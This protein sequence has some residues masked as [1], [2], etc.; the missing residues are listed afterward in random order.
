MSEVTF[1]T[2]QQKTNEMF[3]KLHHVRANKADKYHIF[4]KDVQIKLK[5][6]RKQILNVVRF[7]CY[8][9]YDSRKIKKEDKIYYQYPCLSNN[10]YVSSKFAI[11]FL[12]KNVD[13]V[14]TS[15]L[16]DTLI[17]Y[18]EENKWNP[19]MTAE[20]RALCELL[21]KEDYTRICNYTNTHITDVQTIHLDVSKLF[22]TMFSS[23]CDSNI[24]LGM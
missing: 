21:K 5:S 2:S 24:D 16:F 17:A 12:K 22:S 14:C 20:L 1:I 11:V 6:N 23:M 10:A 3:E 19:L 8:V 18:M 7:H 13:I 4:Q 15:I 9:C